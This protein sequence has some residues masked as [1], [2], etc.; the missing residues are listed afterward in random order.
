MADAHDEERRLI[1]VIGRKAARRLRARERERPWFGLGAYGVVGWSIVLPTLG[2][3]ALG[4]W[5]DA[6]WPSRFSWALMLMVGGLLIGCWN[7][8]HWVVLEQRA[9]HDESGESADGE[10]DE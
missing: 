8:W 6:R 3:I 9:I 4:V 7:A 10:R 1:H 2:G 5:I